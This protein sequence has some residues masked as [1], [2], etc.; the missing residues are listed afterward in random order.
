MLIKRNHD[1]TKVIQDKH[2]GKWVA[3][4]LDRTKVVDYDADIMELEKRVDTEKVV[5]M[6]AL[7]RS[8][9][10]AFVERGQ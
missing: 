9:R 7:D 10:Y 8:K 1:L 3:L 4:S 5:Y 2:A 6:K